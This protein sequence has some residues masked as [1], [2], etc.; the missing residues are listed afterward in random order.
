MSQTITII[1]VVNF[2]LSAA[3]QRKYEALRRSY[4]VEDTESNRELL[5][6]RAREK[7]YR[8]RRRRVNHQPPPCVHVSLAI[9]LCMNS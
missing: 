5:L 6:R 4:K 3:V 1:T 8:A 2:L 7:K 9:I